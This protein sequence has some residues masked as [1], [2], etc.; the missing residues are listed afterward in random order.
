MERISIPQDSTIIDSLGDLESI[1][2]S[3]GRGHNGMSLFSAVTAFL[4][5]N[6]RANEAQN[7]PQKAEENGAL[8]ANDLCSFLRLN[9]FDSTLLFCRGYKGASIAGCS[10]LLQDALL[11]FGKKILFPDLMHFAVRVGNVVIDLAHRRFGKDFMSSN[12]TVY[13]DYSSRWSHIETVPARFLSRVAFLG[14]VRHQLDA[15]GLKKI[16]DEVLEERRLKSKSPP[17]GLAMAAASTSFTAVASA[18]VGATRNRRL[19]NS[20]AS[21]NP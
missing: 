13:N 17:S 11:H 18:F 15:S 8:I 21:K 6:V 2:V 19:R 10:D 14:Y 20:A 3:I 4:S 12:N 1:S 5:D 16:L 7:N 9:G